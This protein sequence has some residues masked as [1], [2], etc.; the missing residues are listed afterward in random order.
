MCLPFRSDFVPEH[1]M[2]PPHADELYQ[3][4]EKG[5]ATIPAFDWLWR[6]FHVPS[7]EYA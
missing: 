5:F 6:L 4:D 3:D 1:T 2:R 7:M